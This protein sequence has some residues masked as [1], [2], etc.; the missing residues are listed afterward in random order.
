MA[1]S[2]KQAAKAQDKP[3]QA[4]DRPPEKL[5][6]KEMLTPLAI[7]V[8]GAMIAG[9]IMWSNRLP[10]EPS[11]LASQATERP[12]GPPPAP[13]AD[14]TQ[15]NLEGNPSIGD[16]DAPVVAAYWFDYQCPYCKQEEQNVFPQLIK[17]YVDTGKL[18]IVFK[19]FQFLGPDSQSA[20]LAARAVWEAAPGSFREWHKAVFDKQDNE[21]SG[22]G[23]KDDIIALTRTISGIDT[24]KVEA[25]MTSREADY[26]KAMEADKA[27]GNKMGVNGT[28]SF[29]IGNEMI[30]GAQPYES[31][32]TAIE[33]VLSS[34]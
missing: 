14:I 10:P 1:K 22:W 18:R 13:A 2:G 11:G 3:I 5:S 26:N 34:G 29:I 24:A 25:L 21:N 12:I 20:G 15:V 8:A 33:E 9:S 27:E 16:A 4:A 6:A 19:D 31:L 30:G 17:N 28:P 7:I 23:T 32:K